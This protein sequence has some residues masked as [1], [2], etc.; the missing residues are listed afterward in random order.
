[1][2]I[3]ARFWDQALMLTRQHKQHH[4]YLRI[5]LEEDYVDRNKNNNYKRA[6]IYIES[7][8]FDL[9]EQFMKQYGRL[10]MSKLPLQ[11]TNVLIRLCTDYFQ[12]PESE[13]V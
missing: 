13:T 12:I 11:T 4:L 7:L 1:M 3:Q 10:L 8:P 9:A 2:C 5:L 6:L